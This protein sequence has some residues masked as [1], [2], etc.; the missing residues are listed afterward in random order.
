SATLTPTLL[1]IELLRMLRNPWT[2]G[3][4]LGMPPLLYLL[5]G[6]VPSYASAP[7]PHGNVA[8]LVLVTMAAYGSMVA[9]T[10]VAGTVSEERALGWTRQLR[11]S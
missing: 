2:L 9:A 3:F 8:G 7:L 4:S 11:L 6:A 5:F 10:S 1:R